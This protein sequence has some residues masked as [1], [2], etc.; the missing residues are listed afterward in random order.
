MLCNV[1]VTAGFANY[2]STFCSRNC[3]VASWKEH[4][5]RHSNLRKISSLSETASTPPNENEDNDD[6]KGPPVTS[7]SS[8]SVDHEQVDEWTMVSQERVYTPK[9]EDIG[10]R[11]RLDVYAVSNADNTV[12]TGPTTLFTEP[13]LSA[14][15]KP[16][17]RAL[18]TIPG[19]GSGISGAVRFRIVSYNILAELYAT[20]QAYPYCD[21]WNLSW[22]YRRK[23]LFDELE[24]MQGDIVCLQE[25]QADHYEADISPF[26]N[27][28]GYDGIYKAKSR[29]YMGQYGKVDGCATFWKKNKFLMTE[30][31]G[32][33]FNDMARQEASTLGLD[34]SDARR[35]MNRL[36][37]DNIAQIIVLES[38]SRTTGNR[39]GRSTLC[40]VNT[41][42]YSNQQRPDVKLW[43]TMNLVR[44]VQQFVSSRDLALMIC[45]DFNSEPK[46]AVYEYVTNGSLTTD[47]YPEL[48]VEDS[49]IRILPNFHNI[50]HNMELASAMSTAFGME[51]SYTNYTSKFKGTL[52]YIFYTPTRLRI[53]AVTAIPDENDL[54]HL[55]GEGLPSS[56]Y[57]SDH[58]LMCCDVAMIVSGSGSI[59][60]A[61][62]NGM[63]GHLLQQQPSVMT[64]G[65][66][67]PTKSKK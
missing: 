16:P 67:K 62:M 14:P 57:P 10:T 64:G 49:S 9:T 4:S 17:K 34:E 33:E 18:Q 41:H 31:Y 46:S 55:V 52:D 65:S 58:I 40:V 42:I 51:P 61:D 48:Q 5:K 38:L 15:T 59:F 20:K 21:S 7:I 29:D 19:S 30:N 26:M 35:F 66:Q 12:L 56:C 32:L 53:M 44:E 27:Q 8:T 1:C 6:D 43:Q 63:A 13:V 25:V 11:L 24:E 36:N 39:G 22:P 45:G 3:F 47:T 54:K 60:S 37:R 2:E 23:I 50:I 28:L